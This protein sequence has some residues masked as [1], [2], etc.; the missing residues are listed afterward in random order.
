MSHRNRRITVDVPVFGQ[1]EAQCGVASLKSVLWS[2]G[3]RISARRLAR[4]SHASEEGV[5][6]RPLVA[7]ARHRGFNVLARDRGSIAD[8][9]RLLDQGSPVVV[10][11]WSMD[12]GDRHFD[13]RWTLPERRELDC[14]HYSVVSGIDGRRIRL[15][16]PQWEQPGGRGPWRVVGQRWMSLADFS[17]VWYDTDTDD[18]HKVE[19]WYMVV[20][21]D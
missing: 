15:M 21:P 18:Y 9:R 16:D 4:L 14:G 2:F 19:R 10:G 8:L 6:H 3:D 11:W 13:P 7:A 20:R 12:Q 1:E 17:R 5:N